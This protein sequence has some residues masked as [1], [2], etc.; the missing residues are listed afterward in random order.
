M[1]RGDDGFMLRLPEG[2]REALAALAKNN[3]RS[4][5]SEIVYQLRKILEN[6]KAD[7]TAS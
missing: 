6:E 5:N 3:M 7:A 2:M 1:A 4:M